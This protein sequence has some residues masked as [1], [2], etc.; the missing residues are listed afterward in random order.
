M[1][2]ARL[3]IILLAYF[4]LS[5]HCNRVLHIVPEMR[6]QKNC[7]VECYSLQ[8]ILNNQ[9]YYFMSNTTLKFMPGKFEI[10]ENINFIASNINK[11]AMS[12]SSSP[13]IDSNATTI[14]CQPNATFGLVFI[15]CSNVIISNLSISHCSAKLGNS[16]IKEIYRIP[17]ARAFHLQYIRKWTDNMTSC[18]FMDLPCTA[19]I[20]AIEC[21]S[22]KLHRTKIFQAQGVALLSIHSKNV[23][24]KRADFENNQ[25]NCLFVT[26]AAANFISESQFN[27]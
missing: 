3:Y 13:W 12:G 15:N 17:Q 14:H 7:P 25:F 23:T 21:T 4:L 6:F 19:C 9:S 22:I 10:S 2:N 18:E 16:T 8:E 27:F 20:V 1:A 24:I 5:T 11:F 26:L